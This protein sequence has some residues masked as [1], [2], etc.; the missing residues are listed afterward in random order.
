MPRLVCFG[1]I[2][3]SDVSGRLLCKFHRPRLWCK[4]DREP[5]R[6]ELDRRSGE[7]DDRIESHACAG[8][9]GVRVPAWREPLTSK[10]HDRPR[11]A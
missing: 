4:F 6:R 5:R 1:H 9:A 7:F 8:V 2:A 3:F 10:F 11:L